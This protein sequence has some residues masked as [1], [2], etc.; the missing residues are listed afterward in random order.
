MFGFDFIDVNLDLCLKIDKLKWYVWRLCVCFF[1]VLGLVIFIKG[2][3]VG[4]VESYINGYYMKM[5]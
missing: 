2:D 5:V 1:S 3:I 4:G